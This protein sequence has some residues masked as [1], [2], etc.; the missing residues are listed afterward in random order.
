M[1]KHESNIGHQIFVAFIGQ[2]L[3]Q[4][5]LTMAKYNLYVCRRISQIIEQ[6]V[7]VYGTPTI[8]Q[9]ELV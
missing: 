4:S 6:A 7:N 5:L 9:L 3:D 1:A 8:N 2:H